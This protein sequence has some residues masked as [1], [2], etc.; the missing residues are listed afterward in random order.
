MKKL[1]LFVFLSLFIGLKVCNAT[2]K[3]NR[4]LIGAISDIHVGRHGWEAKFDKTMNILISQNPKLDAIFITGDLTDD[5]TVA[6]FELLKTKLDSLPSDIPVY[7][8]MGNHDWYALRKGGVD[9][10]KAFTE[11]IGQ[12]LNQFVDIKGYPFILISME[13]ERPETAYKELTRTY[14]RNELERIAS[15]KDYQEKP[16]FVFLHI[17]NEG[18]SYGSYN[19]G[20]NDSWGT[21]TIKDIFEEYPQI[22]A[23]SGHTHYPLGDPRSIHQDK[24]T[25]INDGSIAY[26]EIE[27]GLSGGTR[28][29]GNN[30][31]IEGC[32]ISVND[33][34]DVV[35]KRW[36]FFRN[37]EIQQP[38]LIKAPHD[39]SQFTYKGQ[40]GKP[41]PRFA[42]DTKVEF[43]YIGKDS[44]EVR[45]KQA[46]DNQVVHHYFIEV[47]DKAKKPIAKPIQYRVFSGFYLNHEMLDKMTWGISGLTPNTTYYVQITAFD[48]FNN[49]STPLLS[50]KFH[51]TK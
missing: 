44:C 1:F 22:I 34:E 8:C 17:P 36:D 15:T 6:E 40:T 9:C 39:G 28:P 31:V 30:E 3:E 29:P 14:L 20:G 10:A 27:K 23:I 51:T 50:K 45:F 32:I 42:L 21:S 11:K 26:S 4:P 37:I 24:F 5:G 41:A 16:V 19:I 35:V 46:T 2:E 18:T 47:L 25:S 7:C 12:P 13:T 49:T 48:S 43:T 33:S 38:W